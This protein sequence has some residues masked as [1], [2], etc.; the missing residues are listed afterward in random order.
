MRAT[1]RRIHGCAL[2][3]APPRRGPS[4]A[5]VRSERPGVGI[6]ASSARAIPPAGQGDRP[7]AVVKVPGTPRSS[8]LPLSANPVP[9]SDY[10]SRTVRDPRMSPSPAFPRSG[11]DDALTQPPDSVAAGRTRRCGSVADLVPSSSSSSAQDRRSDG[12]PSGRRTW[13]GG[14]RRCLTT[15]PPNCCVFRW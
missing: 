15:V 5:I 10:Q 12:L 11:A 4:G 7:P 1:P 13:R 14:R 3:R 8:T 9:E 2:S 6:D